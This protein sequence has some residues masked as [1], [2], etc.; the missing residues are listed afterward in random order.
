MVVSL[1]STTNIT[2]HL[3]IMELVKTTNL[4]HIFLPGYS[5]YR[6]N[7][8][9]FQSDPSSVIARIIS[10]VSWHSPLILAKG[11]THNR[12]SVNGCKINH[13]NSFPLATVTMKLTEQK[14]YTIVPEWCKVQGRETVVFVWAYVEKREHFLNL[15]NFGTYPG[16]W[17]L[18]LC[19]LHISLTW[20]YSHIFLPHE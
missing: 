20:H 15:R 8:L 11:F 10:Y 17:L 19:H 4:I 14:I 9:S 7:V 16:Q 18:V 1:T 6:C 2:S 3:C 13:R 12:A 5:F